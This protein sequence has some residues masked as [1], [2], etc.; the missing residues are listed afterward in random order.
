MREVTERPEAV[1]CGGAI[2]AGCDEGIIYKLAAQLL[3]DPAA[4]AAM[5]VRRF[6]YG[7][8]NASRRI[9]DWLA[10]RP[11]GPPELRFSQS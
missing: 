10:L 1:E 4:H 8:G 2:L 9:L 11:P 3:G 6:P 5:A 7:D